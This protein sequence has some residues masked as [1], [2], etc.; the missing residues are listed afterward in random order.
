VSK[1]RALLVAGGALA[2]VLALP[3]P[4]SAHSPDIV[5]DPDPTGTY[6]AQPTVSGRA[7]HGGELGA[8]M[9]R[10]EMSWQSLT[11][12]PSSACAVPG[13]QTFPGG[14][15]VTEV[16]FSQTPE[17]PCNGH[18][19]VVVDAYA[20]STAL[21]GGD[22]STASRD[23]TL[24]I[25]PARVTRLESASSGR[26]VGLTWKASPEPDR[27]GYLIDRRV[28]SGSY[29]EGYAVTT[30]S[31][32]TDTDLPSAGGEVTYRV[33][34]VRLGSKQD[35]EAPEDYV[36]AE[37]PSSSASADVDAAPPSTSSGGSGD[38]GGSGS[39]GGSG[40]S[41]GGGVTIATTPTGGPAPRADLSGFAA[42]QR[43]V[44]EER[45]LRSTTTDPGFAETLPYDAEGGS[46]GRELAGG[47]QDRS[48]FEDVVDRKAVL[49]PIAG[50]LLLFVGA[51]QL[52]YLARRARPEI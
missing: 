18:Y 14:S 21:H 26:E 23:L 13:K 16:G 7:T 6:S 40:G 11:G 12:H 15:G 28:G 20:R 44:D 46:G 5:F 24:R 32:F 47:P 29:V 31:S 25:P 1:L 49:V 33:W 8:E 42:L 27:V 43:Q 39:G 41:G 45:R 35:L 34:S 51:L 17:F 38:G 30:V 48:T 3:H 2:L 52:R 10:V 50:G 4:A 19:A 9:D 22:S 37:H 36:S